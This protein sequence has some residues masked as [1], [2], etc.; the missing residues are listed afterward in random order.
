MRTGPS[1]PEVASRLAVTLGD[2][3]VE[4]NAIIR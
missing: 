4:T 2:Y 1:S 3:N